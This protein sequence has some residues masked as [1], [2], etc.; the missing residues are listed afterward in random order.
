MTHPDTDDQ[1]QIQSTSWDTRRHSSIALSPWVRILGKALG[2]F[3]ML[4]PIPV[5]KAELKKSPGT[6]SHPSFTAKIPWRWPD[7]KTGQVIGVNPQRRFLFFEISQTDTEAR[8]I[9][10]LETMAERVTTALRA[11]PEMS[12][13]WVLQLFLQDA[14]PYSLVHQ[15]RQYIDEHAG[16]NPVGDEWVNMVEDH[17]NRISQPAGYFEDPQTRMPWSARF[18][19]LRGLIYREEGVCTAQELEQISLRLSD[20]LSEAGVRFRVIGGKEIYEW[21][22]P[23]LA[24]G[25]DV[26]RY[27]DTYPYPQVDEDA[28]LLPASFDLAEM[29]W[30][31]VHIES[32][33]EQGTWSFNQR[34]W[35]YLP[36]DPPYSKPRLGHWTRASDSDRESGQ[37][38]PFDRLP[39]GSVLS[40]TIASLPQDQVLEE[41]GKVADAAFGETAESR[42]ANEQYEEAKEWMARGH[43]MLGMQT[44][45]FVHGTDQS[46]VDR[47]CI[48]AESAIAAAGFR[49]V[50]RDSDPILLDTAAHSLPGCW[51]W[52]ND[53]RV[54]KRARLAWDTHAARLL[55][56]FG[57]GT[58]SGNPGVLAW[59]RVGE[60]FTF[61]PLSPRDRRKN[62]HLFLFGPPGAGKT[63]SLVYMLMQEMAIHRPRLY[64]I[65]ALPTFGLLGSW[66]TSLGLS[67]NH[68]R[69]DPSKPISLPPFSAASKILSDDVS[70]ET[71]DSL[72]QMELVARLMITGGDPKEEEKLSR[73]DRS[74]IRDAILMAAETCQTQ[75]IQVRTKH[76][77]EGLQSLA[78]SDKLTPTQRERCSE[79]A[80]AMGLFCSGLTGEFFNREGEAWPA[81]DVTIVELGAFARKGAEDQLAVAMVGLMNRINDQVEREQ[82]GNRQS[83]TL[84]DEAHLLLKNALLSPYLNS[85][86]A[87]WRTFGS[88]LWLAT[89][90]MRQ[91]PE[92]SKELL[93]LA[94]WWLCLNI[95]PDDIAQI[96]RFKELTQE[97]EDLLK[98]T[99][100]ERFYTEGVV[101]ARAV[102]GLF[103]H[104]LPP[105]ALALAQTEKEEKAHRAQLMNEHGCSE[106][107][108]ARLVA[109]EIM[110]SR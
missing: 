50:P 91:F 110:A 74:R 63:A 4:S 61:D 51:S 72:S 39:S 31:G 55:P 107:D 41:M 81:V 29:C 109:Q 47:Q 54:G 93:N 108:A 71:G 48:Q 11:I 99:R 40:M 18:R 12:P 25:D 68:V 52:Q 15:I 45:V 27:L 16:A 87:M 5:T 96:K 14:H 2:V 56:V 53:Q 42:M 101:I 46:D 100:K 20:A 75:G 60:P 73:G 37:P 86:S 90:S 64:C 49:L 21:L 19:H 97:Q 36:L 62:G 58:G 77:V 38:A 92:T 65:T 66:F 95:E 26:Y 70:D 103:R 76:I 8:D 43:R 7:S 6:A 106:L 35:R 33:Q 105:L 67:V 23:W 1:E 83:I 32:D 98:A 9:T 104:V 88:W 85:M 13:S 59:N 89:Q 78:I 57:R 30:R 69:V 24:P 102:T 28:G 3:P 34:P 80:A 79:M 10:V 94:E 17:I 22:A 84:I 82:F 44:G